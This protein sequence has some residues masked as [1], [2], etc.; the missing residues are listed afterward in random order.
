[1]RNTR[2]DRVTTV[3]RSRTSRTTSAGAGG[4][5]RRSLVSEQKM[6]SIVRYHIGLRPFARLG[7]PSYR[8]VVS[9]RRDAS[10]PTPRAARRAR[11]SGPGRL[12]GGELDSRHARQLS[13]RRPPRAIARAPAPTRD[14]RELSPLQILRAPVIKSTI[15]IQQ[16]RNFPNLSNTNFLRL[17]ITI[18]PRKAAAQRPITKRFESY[19]WIIFEALVAVRHDVLSADGRCAIPGETITCARPATDH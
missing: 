7:A 6:I 4:A 17:T 18:Q 1:M 2:P 8:A 16:R 3:R 19:F 12:V 9:V 15:R 13:H 5:G 11:G 10:V 14:F